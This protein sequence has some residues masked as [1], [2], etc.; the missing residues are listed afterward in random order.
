MTDK[1]NPTGAARYASSSLKV[2]DVVELMSGGPM[3]TVTG[4]ESGDV[5]CDWFA[6]LDAM[7]ENFIL[8]ALQ[9]VPAEQVKAGLNSL[10]AKL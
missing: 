9:V 2:G 8:A 5:S 3:M 4:V 10:R 1:E 6:G 7:S